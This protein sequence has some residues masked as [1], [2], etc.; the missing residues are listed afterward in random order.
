MLF[1]GVIRLAIEMTEKLS[2]QNTQE[3]S[4]INIPQSASHS[5]L[6]IIFP[7]NND[8]IFIMGG[9]D[10]DKGDDDK[11]LEL[12]LM[13]EQELLRL[14][15]QFRV[16]FTCLKIGC[17][18]NF[19]SN[20][21]YQVMDGD[22]EAY[23]EEATKALRRQR[24][25]LDDLEKEKSELSRMKRTATSK[26]NSRRDG[27][28]A[29]KIARLAEEQVGESDNEKSGLEIHFLSYISPSSIS[30]HFS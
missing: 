12:D 15:R 14:T 23:L 21:S 11:D 2:P 9:D 28:N 20:S 27:E 5:A 17:I 16:C 24:K 13:A 8:K 7:E 19:Q 10:P 6:R 22:K 18:P 4:L 25:I 26:R 1:A 3:K 30:R 29:A